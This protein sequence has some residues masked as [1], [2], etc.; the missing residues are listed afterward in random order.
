MKK[1]ALF[2]SASLVIFLSSGCIKE[3]DPCQPKTV[4]SEDAA[5]LSYAS[6]NGITPTKHSSGMYY[7]ITNAG[8]GVSPTTSSTVTVKYTG[9]L[10]DGTIFDQQIVNAQTFPLSNVIAG[11][12]IGV[13][14]IKKGGTIKL[15]IP[16]LYGYGCTANGPIPAY[17]ILYFEI[18]LIDV[19]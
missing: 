13:P 19:L 15:I 17:S 16:S 7:Q 1:I 3:S 8:T 18:E 12:Q 6:A 2:L 5:M 11:W 9:K 4:A 14:L 10:T